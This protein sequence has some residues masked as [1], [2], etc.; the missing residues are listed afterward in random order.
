MVQGGRLQG[1]LHGLPELRESSG[2]CG[3][4][5]RA[6][7]HNRQCRKAERSTQRCFQRLQKIFI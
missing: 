4:E 1:E 3:K 7:V 5:K 6:R 2:E